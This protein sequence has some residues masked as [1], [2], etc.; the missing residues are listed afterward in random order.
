M[1]EP[2]PPG[3]NGGNGLLKIAAQEW[4]AVRD[5]RDIARLRRF[6]ASFAG[7]YYAGEARALRE[8]LEAEAARQAR[9]VKAKEDR[10]RAEGR[11]KLTGIIVARRA[12][13]LVSAGRGQDGM[14]SGFRGRTG[15][16]GRPRGLFHDG[17]A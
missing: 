14:V 13:G 2:K 10:W 17:V 8:E 16:G 12:G 6:E 4:P 9:A 11:I 3:E 5:S 1:P 15:D 7:T